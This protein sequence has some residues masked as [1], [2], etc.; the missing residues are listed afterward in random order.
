MQHPWS[1]EHLPR[2]QP[3]FLKQP[4]CI[5]LDYFFYLVNFGIEKPVMR[6]DFV[7]L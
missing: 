4:F 2:D 7:A 5:S 6:Y 3:N 1:I